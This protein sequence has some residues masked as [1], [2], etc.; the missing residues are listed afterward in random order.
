MFIAKAGAAVL[1]TVDERVSQVPDVQEHRTS[2]QPTLVRSTARVFVQLILMAGILY[3]SFMI[4]QRMIANQPTAANRPA[5]DRSIPV[6]TLEIA[7]SD[8]RPSLRLFGEIVAGRTIEV[9]PPAGG[10]VTFV[11]ENLAVGA[12]VNQGDLLFSIDPFDLEFALSEAEANLAQTKATIV[13]NRAR[14]AS[15]TVQWENAREQFEFAEADYER[16]L[17]LRDN[18]TLTAKQVEDRALLVSQ[19]RQT[20]LLRE[21]N[22]TVEE[23]RLEQQLAAERRLQLSVERAQRNLK[24]A[25]V[26]APFSGIVRITN[27]EIGRQVSANEVAVEMYDDMALDARFTLTDAQ[28]GRIAVDADPLIGRQVELS[29][30]VG[31]SQYSYEAEVTRLGAEVAS[32][33]GGVDVFAR[34]SDPTINEVQLRPGAFIAL[35]V[36]DRLY[37]QT[38]RVPEQAVFDGPSVY[39]V[40]EGELVRQDIAVLAYDGAEAVI[41]GVDAGAQVLATRLSNAE[42]GLQVRTEGEGTSTP[43]RRQVRDSLANEG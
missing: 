5:F 21:N 24:D 12:R 16:A 34:V 11:N 39:L 38:A 35:S 43:L 10:E 2:R 42:N 7:L 18:G 31:G 37:S 40:V 14:I 1:K 32:E 19:R 17:A 8:N 15:E 41:S 23:A 13:E 29:W 4:M 9:R 3:G 25:E 22:I 28:Y 27:V 26:T 6:Q 20:V 30:L 33:R 36:P